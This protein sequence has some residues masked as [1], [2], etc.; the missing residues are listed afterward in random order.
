LADEETLNLLQGFQGNPDIESASAD[1]SLCKSEPPQV[2]VWRGRNTALFSS[3]NPGKG[4]KDGHPEQDW[5]RS[6][7]FQENVTIG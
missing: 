2:G 5:T 7:N 6:A 3:A 1:I 4:P